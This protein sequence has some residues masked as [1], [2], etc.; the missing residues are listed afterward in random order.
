LSEW[1]FKSNGLFLN[2]FR[3]CIQGDLYFSRLCCNFLWEQDVLCPWFLKAHSV[4]NFCGLAYLKKLCQTDC[5]HALLN[6][7]LW[8]FE[9]QS[10][11]SMEGFLHE[12]V[13]QRPGPFA[14][15]EKGRWTTGL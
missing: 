5:I 7:S 14:T 4:R 15:A 2:A 3:W 11:L 6:V 1:K 13:D 10:W 12:G 8:R 9:S